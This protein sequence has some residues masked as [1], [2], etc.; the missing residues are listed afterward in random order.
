MFSCIDSLDGDRNNTEGDKMIE[1]LRKI[2]SFPFV[3]AG[4]IL[5]MMAIVIAYGFKALDNF[6]IG[7]KK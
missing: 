5:L 1:T 3:L 4:A 2:I 6:E 7:W